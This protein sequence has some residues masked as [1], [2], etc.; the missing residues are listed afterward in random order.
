MAHP[1]PGDH[2][3]AE[4]LS[5]KVDVYGPDASAIIRE[6]AQQMTASELFAWWDK[7]IGWDGTP[8][9]ALECAR[10]NRASLLAKAA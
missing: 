8:D 6:I 7:E 1:T 4:I 5:H 3:L 9:R 2:P 10:D